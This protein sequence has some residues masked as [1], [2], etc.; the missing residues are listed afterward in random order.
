LNSSA[1]HFIACSFVLFV[2]VDKFT[3]GLVCNGMAYKMSDEAK[4]KQG[5]HDFLNYP[6]NLICTD[7]VTWSWLMG[8]PRVQQKFNELITTKLNSPAIK[9]AIISKIKKNGFLKI[10]NFTSTPKSFST[11]TSDLTAFHSAWQIQRNQIDVS[12][13]E[14]LSR[15]REGIDDLTAACAGFT[16]YLAIKNFTLVKNNDMARCTIDEIA[17]YTIDD[18]DFNDD[19]QYLGHW[20]KDD[21]HII[22]AVQLA[23]MSGVEMQH[24]F[25]V[26]PGNLTL[27]GAFFSIFNHQY[28]QYRKKYNKGGDMFVFSPIKIIPIK[29]LFVEII[30]PPN[31][32]K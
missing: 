5:S 7:L 12:K 27:Q 17:V 30:L 18:F 28:N 3:G 8:F 22:P 25:Q 11:S 2:Q 6:K 16:M 31:P 21:V 32:K 19:T 9:D 13:S 4:A 1:A 23:S 29:N 14:K 20:N 15:Y 24:P 26:K 10:E